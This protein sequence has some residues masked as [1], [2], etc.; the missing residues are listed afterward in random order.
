MVDS[1]SRTFAELVDLKYQLYN[2]LFLTL[3]LDA[4]EQTGLL[5]PLLE[6]ACQ[7]GLREGKDPDAIIDEFF[8]TH[9]SGFDEQDKA[10]FLFK[11]I[12]YVERQVVLVDALE[13]AAYNQI[14][15]LD[16]HN[17]LQRILDRV[18]VEDD[19]RRFS[20]ILTKFGIRVTLTAHPTQFYT[21]QVLAIIH[22]LSNAI[23]EGDISTVRE[24][25]LQLGNTPFYR[26]DKPSPY[27]EAV[28]L[29]WYLGNIF[30]PVM[31]KMMDR[32]ADRHLQEV[33][34]NPH[35]MTI[36]FWPGGD[37]DGNPFVT[38]ETTRRV[39]AKLRY[40][41]AN[42][43]H[44]DIRELKRR[45]TFPGIYE[46][47]E[48][49]EKLLH[50]ELSETTPRYSLSESA[51]DWELEKVES[52]LLENNQGLYVNRLRSFRRKVKL[53]GFYFASLDIRQDGRV[54]SQTLDEVG[55]RYPD[56]ISNA[57]GTED[58]AELLDI[59]FGIS[60]TIDIESFDE[61][62]LKDT[63]KSFNV[64]RE[65]Q[66]DNGEHGCHRY[67]IS[68]CHG[69]VDMARSFALFQLCGWK[70]LPLSVDIVPLFE[71]V[72]DLAEAGGS[73][74]RIYANPVYRNHLRQRGNRQTIMLGFSDGTKDG[75]YLMA[76]W[77][78]YRAKEDL[79][80]VSREAGIEVIFFDG[81]GGPT[82]RGG[83]NTYL[84]YAALGKKIESNQIQLTVQGQ[85]VSSHYGTEQAAQHNLSQLLVAG[86]ENNLDDRSE[87][88]L[89]EDQRDLV[90]TLATSSYKKY[91]ALKEHDLFLPYLEEMST[92][93]FYNLANIGSRPARRGNTQ[94][95]RF[96]D[97][98]AI[99]FVGAWGQLKQNVPGYY[100][101]GS[102]LQEQ[103]Q[104]GNLKPCQALYHESGFF[105][106]LI[107][108]AMQ[109]LAK[110]NFELT[111]YMENDVRFGQ[112][113]RLI[114][115]EYQ[116]T[117]EMVLKVSGQQ[118]LL[119]DNPRA[120]LSIELRENIV[121]PL[122]VL[123]QAALMRC[124]Q[125]RKEGNEEGMELYEKMIV[126]SL[127]GNINASRNS[128]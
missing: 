73:M 122:L 14:H 105:R 24:L 90:Q 23:E 16:S 42:C 89:N 108:N 31:G 101:L 85:T 9:K 13:D 103:E 54:I 61:P 36:G 5:L 18:E 115:E 57:A 19:D 98:R 110:S 72:K 58:E 34:Q 81:R 67:I 76:N 119:E 127:Y 64:I 56:L 10:G 86:L 109:N 102:C 99:P 41:I 91:Q 6:V 11:I 60:G 25:L 38:A 121:L 63:L 2:G 46:I 68:N 107:S 97:L 27:D 8:S 35:L 117:L 37:R 29:T 50:E 114:Y 33:K 69:P 45:L 7:E 55:K 128:A 111:R 4:V 80:A 52:L 48:K 30:Y 28:L 83:G 84:F 87:R 82:A 40:S 3:P 70:D 49:I 22:D 20:E 65:I 74:S 12:Q 15:Q 100:G 17:F 124:H 75:G 118:Y 106:A 1:I 120:R 77:A 93:K 78:I 66:S 62:V 96:E 126:R 104:A 43:Y 51:L 26:K 116:L 94:E 32:L 21:G 123:Q 59:L 39:A 44:R 53:F 92:L 71:S 79:T 112:F 47:L 113:W 88:E 95:L 125:L